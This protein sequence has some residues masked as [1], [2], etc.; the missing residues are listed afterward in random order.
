MLERRKNLVSKPSS[1]KQQKSR[2]ANWAI[3]RLKGL[4]GS[5]VGFG[6]L[7]PSLR[8]ALQNLSLAIE[9]EV[10]AVKESYKNQ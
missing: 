9:N 6:F 5:L 10:I 1:I 7:Y 3:F 8:P 2:K 4:Q